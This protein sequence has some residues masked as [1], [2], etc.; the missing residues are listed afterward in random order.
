MQQ[1]LRIPATSR[2]HEAS[3]AAAEPAPPPTYQV[4]VI[5]AVAAQDHLEEGMGAI[6]TRL[7]KVRKYITADKWIAQVGFMHGRQEFE[8]YVNGTLYGSENQI[9][10]ITVLDSEGVKEGEFARLKD[11]LG[12]AVPLFYV[13][14]RWGERVGV[15][16]PN[17]RG[18]PQG[19]DESIFQSTCAAP[20]E[21]EFDS[22]DVGGADEPEVRIQASNFGENEGHSSYMDIG[23]KVRNPTDKRDAVVHST[24]LDCEGR[25]ARRFSGHQVQRASFQG[26]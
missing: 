11:D 6:G 12:R 24:P 16:K 19:R 10:L 1:N 13:L 8:R 25:P 3:S 15:I 14:L 7:R 22:L 4:G 26:P 18:Q 23:Y 2:S 5:R 21:G 20:L 17:R 9:I